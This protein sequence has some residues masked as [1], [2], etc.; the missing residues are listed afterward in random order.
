MFWTKSSVLNLKV[1]FKGS[2]FKGSE[3]GRLVEF[4]VCAQWIAE[5]TYTEVQNN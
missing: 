2:A 3:V 5:G 1:G 4:K